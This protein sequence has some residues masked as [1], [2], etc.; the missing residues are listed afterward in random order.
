M[1]FTPSGSSVGVAGDVDL[2][3]GRWLARVEGLAPGIATVDVAVANCDARATFEVSVEGWPAAVS[4]DRRALSL[5]LGASAVLRATVVNDDGTQ[6]TTATLK[7]QPPK[8]LQP[9]AD[10]SLEVTGPGKRP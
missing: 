8:K 7:W 1:S 10:V 2:T 6:N 5:K 3:T 9:P 4:V